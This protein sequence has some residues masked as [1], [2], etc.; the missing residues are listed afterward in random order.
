MLSPKRIL[1]IAK[2]VGS[3][4]LQYKPGRTRQTIRKREKGLGGQTDAEFDI[5]RTFETKC[6][7]LAENIAMA[8]IDQR[9]LRKY[10][11]TKKEI[12]ICELKTLVDILQRAVALADKLYVSMGM[13]AREEFF[14]KEDSAPPKIE[15]QKKSKFWNQVLMSPVMFRGAQVPLEIVMRHAATCWRTRKSIEKLG[16]RVLACLQ[17]KTDFEISWNNALDVVKWLN[18]RGVALPSE[19][20]TKFQ[21][22]HASIKVGYPC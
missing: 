12:V 18:S 4:V 16:V 17:D 1:Y 7:V 15:F 20:A 22:K 19:P 2:E 13:A 8:E 3:P 6:E 14:K 21:M 5:L 10:P 11:G 9:G